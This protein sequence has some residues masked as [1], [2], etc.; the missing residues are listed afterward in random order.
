MSRPEES[1]PDAS[2]A[3]ESLANQSRAVTA[4]PT[5]SPGSTGR[6]SH[7]AWPSLSGGSRRRPASAASGRPTAGRSLRGRPGTTEPIRGLTAD[8]RLV[9]RGSLFVAVPGDHVDGH[10]FVR[11]A[12][13]AGAPA[14]IVEEPVADAGLVQ[15][16]VE[17]EPR[18][19]R[20]RSRLVVRRP[21]PGAGDHRDHGH[22]R[23]DDDRRSWPPPPWLP[24]GIGPGWSGRSSCGSAAGPSRRP[25]TR[26]RPRRPSSSGSSGRWPTAGDAA[27]VVE[28]TSHGLALDRV[29][30]IAYDAAV[31]TNLSHEHLELHGSFEAYRAAKLSLF[32]R[33]AARG[34]AK[35]GAG[36]ALA[37]PRLAVI[38]EDDAAAGLFV[39]V[40]REAGARVLTYGAGPGADVRAGRIEEDARRLFVAYDA[41][42]GPAELRLQLAGRFN[43]HNAL[44]AVALGEGLGLDPAGRPGGHR[45]RHRRARPD[46]ADRPRPAV[47]G[48]RR[49]RP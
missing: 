23:Q 6:A 28:T 11:Q 49:L 12:A 19:P 42:S 48:D 45:G 10:E 9:G 38:N 29:G 47:H 26:R 35:T 3:D 34:P 8:S 40:S 44:A 27:A 4:S 16:I 41:P 17:P 37:W 31:L 32:E 36:A 5:S 21:E 24:L 25:S 43:V 1:Q 20:Q 39:A 14:A 22:R 13:A 2:P 33:L 30:G 46:G 15:L 7:G 18:G